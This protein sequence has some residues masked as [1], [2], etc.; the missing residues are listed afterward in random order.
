MMK[1]A[2]RGFEPRRAVFGDEG[3]GEAVWEML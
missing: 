2:R 3:S 1:L